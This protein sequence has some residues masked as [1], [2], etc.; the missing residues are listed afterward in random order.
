MFKREKLYGL[1]LNLSSCQNDEFMENLRKNLDMYL[2]EKSVTY[3]N[4]SEQAGISFSTLNSL[5][6]GNGKDCNLSTVIKLSKALGI[7]MDELVGAN[8]M[9]A[10]TRDYVAKLRIMPPHFQNLAKSYIRHVY[11]LFI[12]TN[13]PE[14]R[15]VLLPEFSGEH[16]QT[17]NVTKTIDISHLERSIIP[18]VGH[19]LRIPCDHYEPYF[20]RD[21][22]VLLGADRDAMNN[23]LCVISNDG[24]YYI[25]RKK[26]FIEDG[27]KKWKY[28]S[29]F[30]DK[31]F[32]KDEIEEKLGY[33]VGFL[34]PDNSWGER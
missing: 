32:L 6:N 28:M 21:E 15:L 7:T 26:M 5:M 25:V 18:K 11:K 23:E 16:L 17:T 12:K 9:D 30:T 13:A 1:A 20:L 8:T 14:P 29:L 2:Q 10:D 4:L 22:I 19:C 3:A 24:Q 33:I 34:N 31:E 27:V